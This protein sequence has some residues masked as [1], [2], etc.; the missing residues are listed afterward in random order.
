GA[1]RNLVA[2][3]LTAELVDDAELAG[4]RHRDPVTLLMVHG[5][6][7]VQTRRTFALDLHG[8]GGRRPRGRAADVEGAH[9]ELRARLA[10][11]LRGDDADRL[12]EIDAM[13]ARQI[14][15]VALSTDAIARLTGDRR[16]HLHLIDAFL[17]EQLHQPLV[18]QRACRHDHLVAARLE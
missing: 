7:I 9:R 18:D 11:R 12:A 3:P 15:P 6:Q 2:L 14:A 1:I 17:L 4:T 5:L 10:D 8:I 13:T 16:T